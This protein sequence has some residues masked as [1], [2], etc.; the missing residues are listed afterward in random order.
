MK[1]NIELKRIREAVGDVNGN[2]NSFEAALRAF[3]R[4]GRSHRGFADAAF[5]RKDYNSRFVHYDS[6]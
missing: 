2:H 1:I 6:A 3:R 5:S 4:G